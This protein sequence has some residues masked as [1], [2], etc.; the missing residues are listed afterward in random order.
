M[1]DRE[2][3]LLAA[4][5]APLLA[6]VAYWVMY[7]LTRWPES[8]E[9]LW[10]YL[11]PGAALAAMGAYLKTLFFGVPAYL[12]LHRYKLASLLSV[13]AVGLFIPVASIVLSELLGTL[14]AG[15]GSTYSYFRENCHEVID[16]VRTECGNWL[17]WRD[18][19]LVVT[20]GGFCG[21]FFWLINAGGR[22]SGSVTH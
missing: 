8:A 6:G 19:I 21:L 5:L 13:V 20:T 15:S 10:S 1:L 11:M 14:T 16:N 18:R 12:L 9:L 7:S 2:R 4:F 17:L 3:T 22:K